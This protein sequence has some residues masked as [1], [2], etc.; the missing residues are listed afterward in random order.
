MG[1][2][3]GRGS[4]FFGLKTGERWQHPGHSRDCS[5]DTWLSPCWAVVA[6][7]STG[8]HHSFLQGDGTLCVPVCPPQCGGQPKARQDPRQFRVGVHFSSERGTPGLAPAV[9]VSA[10]HRHFFQDSTMGLVGAVW[11][12]RASPG[13]SMAPRC[14]W[15]STRTQGPPPGSSQGRW[16]PMSP[17]RQ[18]C[19]AL[20]PGLINLNVNLVTKLITNVLSPARVGCSLGLALRR[21]LRHLRASPSWICPARLLPAGGGPDWCPGGWCW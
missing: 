8:C 13:G 1:S 14:C 6:A 4:G 15:Q 18:Q 10:A 20:H 12:T 3:L 7:S 19:L 16:K 17:G 9:L 5:G 11:G 21:L 2:K